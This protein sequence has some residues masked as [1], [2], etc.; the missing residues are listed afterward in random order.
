MSDSDEDCALSDYAGYLSA[1]GAAVDALGA[2]EHAHRQALRLRDSG[3]LTDDQVDHAELVH[4]ALDLL[5]STARR[6][7]IRWRSS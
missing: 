6:V 4:D 7:V 3:C 2:A 5:V 1:L